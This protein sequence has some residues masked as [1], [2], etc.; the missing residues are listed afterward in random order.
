MPVY[1]QILIAFTSFG[2]YNNRVAISKVAD[3]AEVR[4]ET[5][6]QVKVIF[7]NNFTYN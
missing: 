1:L 7:F 4:H 5:V 2:V 3:W 6:D